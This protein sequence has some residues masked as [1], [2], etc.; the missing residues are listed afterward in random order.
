MQSCWRAFASLAGAVPGLALLSAAFDG[1]R[2]IA[3][4]KLGVAFALR[5]VALALSC[6]SRSAVS[7][8]P[9]PHVIAVMHHTKSARLTSG[10][11]SSLLSGAPSS[12]IA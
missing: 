5:A 7:S 12:A 1:K 11:V 6:I 3:R 2:G 9:K 8:V 10:P 4:G